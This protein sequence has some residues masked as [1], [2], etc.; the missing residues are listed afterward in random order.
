VGYLLKDRVT[1]IGEFDDAV[2]RVAAGG[3]AL[4]P[5]ADRP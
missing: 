3:T 4:D 1:D 5:E 2:R